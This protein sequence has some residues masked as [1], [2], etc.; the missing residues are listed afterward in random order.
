MPAIEAY[1]LGKSYGGVTLFEDATF[2]VEAGRTVALVGANGAG[3]S[4]LLRILAGRERADHGTLRVDAARTHVA[5][6]HPHVPAGATVASLLLAERPV[7]PTL[8]RRRGELEARIADP[9]LYER[10]GFEAVLEE[11]A[12]LE[13]Q[14]KEAVRPEGDAQAFLD[15]AGLPFAPDQRADR[16]SG[17]E[18]ARLLLARTLQAARPGDL[19]VLDEPTNHLDVD[20]IEGL[21]DWVGGFDGTVVVVAHDRVFL[22]MVADQVLEVA[23]GRITSTLGGYEDHV[24]ARDEALA[25]ARREHRKAAERVEAVKATVVQFRHQKRFDGQY[26]SR[27][28]ALEKYR[29]ALEQSPDPVLERLGFA[30]H[31]EAA[32]KSSDEMLRIAGLRKAYGAP[33]LDGVEMELR[34]GDRVG[35]VGANGAGKSTLLRILTG[36]ETKDAGTVHAAPGVKGAF[37]SQEHDDLDP[38]RD[39]HA[40]VRDARPRLEDRDVKAL[41]GSFRLDTDPRPVG[42]LSG[43][44][45][46]RL[47]LLKCILRPSN[48]LV[49]DEPT[50][51]LDLDARDIVVRALNAYPGTL[52]VASHDRYLLDAVTDTTAVLDEGRLHVYPGTFT[53]TR[54]RHRRRQAMKA[55]VRW[56]VRKKFTDWTTSTRYRAG[57]EPLLT[58]PEVEASITLRNAVAN[59]WLERIG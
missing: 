51:H 12:G 30:L 4:T 8:A 34:K 3:K 11:Y 54:D 27:M 43:G 38:Q 2:Q 46:Q 20:A 18:R 29:R 45:R 41:L 24:Q 33:V 52:L 28:K 59:G 1:G 50:N 19:V 32:A 58:D 16:L 55:P 49:L 15:A 53:E 7:P 9:G 23:R 35:L 37:F 39:L 36:R 10:P 17:G 47:K 40:E 56:V 5:D 57:D 21:E 22:D 42:T 13:R 6:Q 48:L 25:Q 31:F 44:E 14:I 26:A